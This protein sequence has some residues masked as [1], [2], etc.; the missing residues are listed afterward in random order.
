[1][2]AVVAGECTRGGSG[3]VVGLNG[4]V[5]LDIVVEEAGEKVSGKVAGAE[6]GRCFGAG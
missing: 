2:G 5:L 1:M 3:P 4:V 6:D